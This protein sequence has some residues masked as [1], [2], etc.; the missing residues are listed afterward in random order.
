M[1]PPADPVDKVIARNKL[2]VVR[3]FDYVENKSGSCWYDSFACWIN[4]AKEKGTLSK[5]LQLLF[6]NARVTH[7]E[8]RAAICN[9]LLGDDC[10]MSE[11]WIKEQ[12]S[13]IKEDVDFGDE[14][15]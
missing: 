6:P 8:V 10:I 1:R 14:K 11:T 2:P 15:R 3:C 7:Q 13:R 4:K 9:Y 12:G 5:H